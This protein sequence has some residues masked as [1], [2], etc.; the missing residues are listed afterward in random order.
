MIDLMK[1]REKI[2]AMDESSAKTVLMTTVSYL[3]I[4]KNGNGGFT[5]DM[6]VDELIKMFNKIPE[7]DVLVRLKREKEDKD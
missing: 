5:S 3:D 1:I 7:P 6:C 2:I 4:V